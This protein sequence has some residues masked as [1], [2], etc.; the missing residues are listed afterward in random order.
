[1]YQL[2]FVLF[3]TQ[4][5][6][7]ISIRNIWVVNCISFVWSKQKD[8]FLH[9]YS[10]SIFCNFTILRALPVDS[11]ITLNVV[12]T[13]SGTITWSL[14]QVVFPYEY[15]G[16]NRQYLECVPQLY[17]LFYLWKQFFL[18]SC[19]GFS[20]KYVSFRANILSKR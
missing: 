3:L 1:M 9:Q 19:E 18:C 6:V 11:T 13:V 10:V 17:I 7:F 20:S 8:F 15:V 14:D 12:F 2:L 16:L 4:V 5:K